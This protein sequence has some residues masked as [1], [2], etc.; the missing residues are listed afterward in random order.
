M[1]KP[2]ISRDHVKRLL[3]IHINE[4]SIEL[5]YEDDYEN[6]KNLIKYASQFLFDLLKGSYYELFYSIID[7]LTALVAIMVIQSKNFN[8]YQH[9]LYTMLLAGVSMMDFF[10]HVF[11]RNMEN[12]D[13]NWKTYFDFILSC[14]IIA[15]SFVIYLY[16]DEYIAIVKI[17][18]F[19]CI[20][21]FFRIFIYYFKFDGKKLKSNII[22]PSLKFIKEIIYQ[23]FILYI[24]FSSLGLNIFGGNIN[25]FALDIY[26]DEMGTDLDYEYVNFNTFLNSMVFFFIVTFNNDWPVL[27]NISIINVDHPKR[28]MMKF[29]FV[30]FKLLVNFILINSLIA[31]IIEIFHEYEKNKGNK[32]HK[33][34]RLHLDLTKNNELEDDDHSD[35]F[36]NNMIPQLIEKD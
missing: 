18:A 33:N 35:I 31:F 8:K 4:P 2:D 12:L 32:T 15:L 6:N 17:W 24:I 14:S 9:F 23:V 34:D 26:N 19:F 27:V 13:R 28:R 7:V 1:K 22:Y 21:K 29:I 25:S 30:F 10:H 3:R 16:A 11:F 20:M 36:E 5:K